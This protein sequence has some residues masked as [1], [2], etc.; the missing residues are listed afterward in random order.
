MFREGDSK[1]EGD[2]TTGDFNLFFFFLL[3]YNFLTLYNTNHNKNSF[4][5]LNV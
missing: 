2:E 5:L 1:W 3:I 4:Y